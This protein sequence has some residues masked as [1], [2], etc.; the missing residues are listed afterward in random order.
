MRE[1]EARQILKSSLE[2]DFVD[3]LRQV[4]KAYR[5]NGCLDIKQA[6]KLAQMS[7]RSLQRKL[8]AEDRSFSVTVDEVR[9]EVA[10]EM[11]QH[12]DVS[13]SD[14][15][16]ELGYSKPNNFARA[17]KRWTGKTPDQFRSDT[18]EVDLA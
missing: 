14:V 2:K 11:L 8:A 13:V 6:A 15:A 4:L 10:I 16:A 5:P 18:A 12:T 9:T 1:S 7:V 17:F 3:A